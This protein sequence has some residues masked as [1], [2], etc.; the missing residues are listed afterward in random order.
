MGKF[1]VTSVLYDSSLSKLLL[2]RKKFV[3]YLERKL[4]TSCL[5]YD[6]LRSE[7]SYSVLKQLE[8][9]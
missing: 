1:S 4:G 7:D 6:C 3:F 2:K 8:G 9:Q 5:A